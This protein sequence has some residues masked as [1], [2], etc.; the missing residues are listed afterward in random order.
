M[1]KSKQHCELSTG[2]IKRRYSTA[3]NTRDLNQKLKQSF[4]D[5]YADFK[6]YTQLQDKTDPNVVKDLI[7]EIRD[8]MS[9]NLKLQILHIEFA[10]LEE[11]VEVVRRIE[12]RLSTD[13][14]DESCK[15]RKHDGHLVAEGQ[16]LVHERLRLGQDAL[17]VQ[18][19]YRSAG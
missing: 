2:P 19:P 1:R 11:L 12:Q 18:G 5:F 3:K 9:G 8:R 7:E 15:G 10:N 17:Q 6:E 14:N 16:L 13:Q 4:D